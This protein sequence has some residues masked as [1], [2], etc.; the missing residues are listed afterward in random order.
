VPGRTGTGQRFQVDVEF[1]LVDLILASRMGHLG[2][3]LALFVGKLLADAALP[4]GTVPTVSSTG[5]GIGLAAFRQGQGI[6]P[7][8][9][10]L[11][12]TTSVINRLRHP[13]QWPLV[14]IKPL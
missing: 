5:S 6:A 14:P 13:P 3:Q 1:A 8:P 4:I 2:D 7:V 12:N 10:V 9:G 11:A